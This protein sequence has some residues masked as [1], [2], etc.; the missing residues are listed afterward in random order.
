MPLGRVAQETTETVSL[1]HEKHTPRKASLPRRGDVADLSDTEK[2]TQR[3]SQSEEAKTMSQMTEQE[4]IPGKKPKRNGGRQ[5]ARCRARKLV[6]KMLNELGR[7]INDL[8]ENFSEEAVN[9]KNGIEQL[10]RTSQK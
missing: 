9:T 2:Q 3:G 5:P 8:S 6:R 4:K 1:G 10:K 7:K